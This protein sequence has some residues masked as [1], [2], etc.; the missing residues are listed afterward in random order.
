MDPGGDAK[1]RRSCASAP[2]KRPWLEERDLSRDRCLTDVEQ[3]VD[4]L[5]G[6]SES[7]RDLLRLLARGSLRTCPQ[8]RHRLQILGAELTNEAFRTNQE[9]LRVDC[10]KAADQA[11]KFKCT[12][13]AR[14][15]DLRLAKEGFAATVTA[16]RSAKTS[17]LEDNKILQVKRKALNGADEEL[18]I[19]QAKLAKVTGCRQELELAVQRHM[20]AII[21]GSSDIQAHAEA[22]LL[23][24][25]RVHLEDSLKN[26]ASSSLKLSPEKRGGFDKAV[27]EQLCCALSKL[28]QEVPPADDEQLAVQDAGSTQR[29]ASEAFIEARQR[30]LQSA[31]SLQLAELALR[32]AQSDEG[33]AFESLNDVQQELAAAELQLNAAR[34][35]LKDFDEGPMTSL[36][37]LDGLGFVSQNDGCKAKQETLDPMSTGV[38]TPV[39]AASVL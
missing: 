31:H 35:V 6:V 2:S 30:Q 20:P 19:C 29:Q 26:A 28:L 36:K 5:L 12:A 1:R 39:R 18:K 25:A 11:E 4:R 27:L 13:K 15:E 37:V 3:A 21:Q 34:S 8:E 24:L 9:G 33:M 32:Q 14:A 22:V 16:F 23:L 10:Q 7:G 17:F 38:P